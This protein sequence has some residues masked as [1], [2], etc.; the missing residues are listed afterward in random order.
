MKKLN[1][2]IVRCSVKLFV[3]LVVMNIV[4]CQNH[5]EVRMKGYVDGFEEWKFGSEFIVLQSNLNSNS[6]PDS[7]I[8]A[9]NTFVLYGKF[10]GRKKYKFNY[11]FDVNRRVYL[12]DSFDIK[13]PF[14]S[15]KYDTVNKKSIYKRYE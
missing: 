12:Y 7:L 13:K 10:N 5:I 1:I 14:N 9:G 11:E 6:I 15:V 3:L 8:C 4:S 2:F